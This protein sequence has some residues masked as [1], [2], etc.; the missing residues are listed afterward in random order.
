MHEYGGIYYIPLEFREFWT[1]FLFIWHLRFK[2][3]FK[4]YFEAIQRYVAFLPFSD[5]ATIFSSIKTAMISEK[6]FAPP[7]TN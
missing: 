3:A 6:R 1:L 2:I 5:S 4:I 7:W